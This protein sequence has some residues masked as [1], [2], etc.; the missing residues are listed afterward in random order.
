M[1]LIKMKKQHRKDKDN[2]NDSQFEN[3]KTITENQLTKVWVDM[4]SFNYEWSDGWTLINQRL[5]FFFWRWV[6]SWLT[7]K[8]QIAIITESLIL[9]FIVWFICSFICIRAFICLTVVYLTHW[10]DAFIYFIPQA[11]G[12]FNRIQF[13]NA[14]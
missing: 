11:N 12:D 10:P 1:R 2:G 5:I 4:F 13:D 3:Y 8:I 7:S 9:F 6:D 14:I